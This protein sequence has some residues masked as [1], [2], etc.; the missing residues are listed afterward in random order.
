MRNTLLL[1]WLFGDPHIDTLD[2]GNYTFNGY[3]EYIMLK[4]DTQN[5]T[6]ELQA[7]T[8]PYTNENGTASNATVFSAFAGKDDGGSTF[9]VELTESKNSK[10]F[11]C[12]IYIVIS[13]NYIINRFYFSG[14]RH[15]FQNIIPHQ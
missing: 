15:P 5:E 12:L 9:Q 3:G 6:F 1:G 2:G 11:F 13:H 4:I 14:S 8:T 10:I 7:R